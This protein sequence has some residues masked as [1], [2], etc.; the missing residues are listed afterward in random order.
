MS[1]GSM[2]VMAA[3]VT[4]EEGSDTKSLRELNKDDYYPFLEQA[5]DTLVVVDFYTDW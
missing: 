3:A 2:L 5:G 1:S 4:E